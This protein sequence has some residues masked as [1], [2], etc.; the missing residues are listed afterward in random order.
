MK[1]EK[2]QGIFERRFS[3][4]A[5]G[6]PRARERGCSCGQDNNR[7]TPTTEEKYTVDAECP[8]HGIDILINML[9][10]R[11][12][13]DVADQVAEAVRKLSDDRKLSS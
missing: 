7:S 9:R 13:L 8:L 3:K 6:S 1:S 4:D 10:E 12:D 11:E 5:P 2:S